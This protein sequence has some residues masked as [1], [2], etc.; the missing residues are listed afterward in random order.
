MLI[1]SNTKELE[2]YGLENIKDD[3]DVRV[4]GGFNEK[5][6]YNE[7]RYLNR[8]TY[9]GSDIKRIINQMKLIESKISK[10]WNDWQRAKYI[11]E[12]LGR[13]IGYNLDRRTYANQQSSNLSILLSRKAICAGYSLL[14]KEMMDRQGIECDYIRGRSQNDKHVWNVLTIDGISF[15]IDLTWDSKAL[16]RGDKELEY[17]GVDYSFNYEHSQDQDEKK[18]NLSLLDRDFV[19]N[20]DTSV[21]SQREEKSEEEIENIIRNAIEQ[22]YK[23]YKKT[24]GNI[25]AKQQVKEAIRQ[26]IVNKDPNYFT[27]TGNART[28]IKNNISPEKMLDFMIEGF[29]YSCISIIDKSILGKAIYDT[30][31]KYDEEHVILALKNYIKEGKIRGFTRDNSERENVEACLKPSIAFEKVINTV[32]DIEIEQIEEL[33]E[34]TETMFFSVDEFKDFELSDMKKKN[35]IPKA[36]EWIKSREERAIN[37]S[38]EK[39]EITRNKNDQKKQETIDKEENR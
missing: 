12:T 28:D 37:S 7:E 34:P 1:V 32:I 15:P 39:A 38:N 25:T 14:F 29:T 5:E 16:R 36:M 2:M 31:L 19:Y 9:K 22:T 21:D 26:Y 30:Y 11:Y 35:V 4:L 8:I 23:K 20:I 6:K 24:Y 27:R 13:S 10:E 3:D 18:Y 33:E 17:F